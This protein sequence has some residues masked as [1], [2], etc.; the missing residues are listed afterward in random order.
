M[1]KL[2]F[3]LVAAI[4]AFMLVA[5]SFHSAY[6]QDTNR[7]FATSIQV[8]NLGSSEA[9]ITI[10]FFPENDGTAAVTFND[11]IAGN[12]QVTYA[13]LD[14]S[15]DSPNL[16]ANFR[17]SAVISS[18]QQVAAIVNIV[19][20][21]ISLSFGGEAYI[22][23]DSGSTEVSLPL[24]FKNFAGFSTFF[25]VQNASSTAANVTVTYTNG[26]TEEATIPANASVR[27]DQQTNTD[28]P[29]EFVVVLQSRVIRTLSQQPCRLAQIPFWPTTAWQVVRQHQSSRWSIRTT[30]TSSQVSASRIEVTPLLK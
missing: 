25:N 24:L 19:S 26:A 10:E 20:P 28:L 16:P 1:R 7:P 21:D 3:V 30:P 15:N 6:A 29:D 9:D 27:F 14:G 11:T 22:G 2:R 18:D 17:G 4:A 13:V 5:G 8:R 23:A 12:D